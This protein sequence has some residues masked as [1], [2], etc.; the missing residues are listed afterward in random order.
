MTTT[1]KFD[2]LG[3]QRALTQACHAPGEIYTSPEIFRREVEVYFKRD[4]LYVGRIE[5]LAA[6]GDYMTL[7][8][9]DEPVLVSRDKKGV[10]HANYNMCAHRGVQ[11]ASG[12]GNT[13]SFKCPYHGWV[14]G[15]DGQ[16]TGA[17]FMADS[18][19][20]RC[21]WMSGAATSS[22]TL[23]LRRGHWQKRWRSSRRTSPSSA[24]SAA[25]SATGSR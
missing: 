15:L 24:G 14:Y 25:V 9:V 11:V 13:R 4:W 5:E 17:A 20:F 19:G 10:L 23:T 7:R 3:T 1:V 12:S 22:L 2:S 8:V 6:P 18:E 21:S 16:L